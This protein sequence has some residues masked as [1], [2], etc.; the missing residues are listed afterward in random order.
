MRILQATFGYYP[1]VAWGGQVRSVHQNALEL[2]RRGHRVTACASN[3]LDKRHR[4]QH[5]SFTDSV[6]GVRVHYLR[7]F[8]IPKW[9]GTLGPSWLGRDADQRLAQAVEES[10]VV[11]VNGVRNAIAFQTIRHAQQLGRPI[12]LQPHGTLPHLVSSIR[13]KRLFDHLFMDHLLGAAD[14]VIAL[15]G[16]EW[17]QIV[18][19]GGDPALIHIVPNGLDDSKFD[20]DRYRG[21]FRRQFGI[22]KGRKLVLFLAR[23]NRKKGTDLLVDAFARIPKSARGGMDLVIAGP[24]DGQL[25][26]AKALVARHGLEGQVLFTGVLTGDDVPAAHVDADVFVL[27]CRVDTFPMTLIE[28]CQAGTPILVT[29]M[30]EIADLL[31]DRAAMVVP[32]DVDALAEGMHRLLTDT[33]LQ[34]RYRQGGQDLM[35]TEFS[36]QA[37]GDR[38]EEIYLGIAQDR[39]A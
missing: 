16:A 11:H 34:A 13:F 19:A 18:T 12:V 9:R 15:Q 28:A 39:H 20:A 24:D 29:E 25:A 36:I 14:A 10:D 17:E 32:V 8:V 3:L 27:P 1:A 21:R 26:E 35:R 31:A 30:C 2:Q 37:V 23:I 5:G 6:E 4:I 33:E 22:P 38:L 7:T